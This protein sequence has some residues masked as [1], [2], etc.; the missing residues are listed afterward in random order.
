MH[1]TIIIIYLKNDVPLITAV[2]KRAGALIWRRHT[3][4]VSSLI[5]IGVRLMIDIRIER[6]P[7]AEAYHPKADTQGAIPEADPCPQGGGGSHSCYSL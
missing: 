6:G 1:N 4:W 3:P 2:K 7:A 5:G